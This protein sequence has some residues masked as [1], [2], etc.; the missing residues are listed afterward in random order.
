MEIFPGITKVVIGIGEIGD[1]GLVDKVRVDVWRYRL[2][3]VARP[4]L[5]TAVFLNGEIVVTV[6]KSGDFRVLRNG[7]NNGAF[8]R[9]LVVQ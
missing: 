7:N 3:A 6:P 1:L 9:L 2:P 4:E 5:A 8:P